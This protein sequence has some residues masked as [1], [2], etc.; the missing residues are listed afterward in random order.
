[1]IKKYAC[2]NRQRQ[3]GRDRKRRLDDVEKNNLAFD[4]KRSDLEV[5]LVGSAKIEKPPR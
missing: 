4:L 2:Q 3:Q 5:W 1:M